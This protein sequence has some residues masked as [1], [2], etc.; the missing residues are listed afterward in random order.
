MNAEQKDD[1]DPQSLRLSILYTAISVGAIV[2]LAVLICVQAAE[3]A[4]QA[5][6]A[7]HAFALPSCCA[8][9]RSAPLAAPVSLE[10]PCSS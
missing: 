1:Y 6:L 4:H 10:L 8:H 9:T 7:A 5:R 3:E 2:I